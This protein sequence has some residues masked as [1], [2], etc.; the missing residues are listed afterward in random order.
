M[1]ETATVIKAKYLLSKLTDNSGNLNKKEF[2]I[3]I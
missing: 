3:K 1:S 2:I